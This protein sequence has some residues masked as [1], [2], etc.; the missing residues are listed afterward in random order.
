[1]VIETYMLHLYWLR[2]WREARRASEVTNVK[3]NRDLADDVLDGAE[4]IAEFLFGDR[5]KRRRVYDLVERRELPVFRLGSN[6]HARKSTLLAHIA[7]QE[8]AS[9]QQQG[10][11]ITIAKKRARRLR[12]E[13]RA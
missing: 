2:H 5:T 9:T 11:E 10:G 6:I 1:M 13:A 12:G 7:E 3:Q 8:A 4:A